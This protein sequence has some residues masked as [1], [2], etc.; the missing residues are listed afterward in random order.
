WESVNFSAD[1]YLLG[2]YRITTAPEATW[3]R[4]L[5]L[6]VITPA[7]GPTMVTYLVMARVPLVRVMVPLRAGW[8]STV[9]PACVVAIASRSEPGSWSVRL[10]TVLSTQRYSRGSGY[11]RLLWLFGRWARR[12]PL[13]KE[14]PIRFNQVCTATRGMRAILQEG[15]RSIYVTEE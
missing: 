6:T 3:N 2:S 1:G 4:S 15:R 5:P 7:P 9:P 11:S 12:V 13:R 10:V 8:K 14:R